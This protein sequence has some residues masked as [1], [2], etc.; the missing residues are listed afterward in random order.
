[1]RSAHKYSLMLALIAAPAVAKTG[2][3]G[4]ISTPPGITLQV[5]GK[6][7]GY[8]LSKQ[9]AAFNPR[10]QIV[11]SDP[12]G[13]TLYTYDK[14]PLG[15]ATCADDCAKSWLPAPAP[16]KPQVFGEWSVIA[17]ADGVRQWAYRGK[18][19]YTFFKDVDPGS[20][21]GNSPARF[22]G[23]RRNGAGEFVGGG[24]RGAAARN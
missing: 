24:V 22:G 13:M 9:T 5:M 4:P 6:A 1:M 16:K 20:V 8:D 7:Q 18:A 23:R 17:R 3:I 2:D 14:D 19:L 21:G 15:K 11:F 12:R 10:E